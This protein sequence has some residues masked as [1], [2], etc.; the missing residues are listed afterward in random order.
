M[1]NCSVYFRDPSWYFN[2]IAD[3][4]GETRRLTTGKKIPVALIFNIG[5]LNG[6]HMRLRSFIILL[7]SCAMLIGCAE[8]DTG[9]FDERLTGEWETDRILSQLGESQSYLQFKQDGTF[10]LRT[11]LLQMGQTLSAEGT[12]S[13]QGDRIFLS[14]PGK[15][16]QQ[17]YRIDNGLLIIH[18]DSGDTF[19]YKKLSK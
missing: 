3:R 5:N 16:L 8:T 2:V 1:C 6:E 19:T 15:S 14:S 18:E 7:I 4:A 11:T 12:F 17:K 10:V 13:T 9:K